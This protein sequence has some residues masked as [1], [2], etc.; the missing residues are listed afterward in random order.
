MTSFHQIMTSVQVVG[1]RMER[2]IIIIIW[3]DT[4]L[5]RPVGLPKKIGTRL[6]PI[7]TRQ[8]RSDVPY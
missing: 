5:T 3:T 6:P 1:F 8:C 7:L 4:A 2:L